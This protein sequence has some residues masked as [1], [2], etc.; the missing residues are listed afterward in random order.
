MDIEQLIRQQAQERG[1]DPDLAVSIARAESSLNPRA[2]NPK[3]S[4]RGLFQVTNDTWKQYG[5]DPKKRMDVNENIRVGLD[6]IA[7]NTAALSSTLGR[8]PRPAE[9]YAA[10]FFG[11]AGA[12]RV[13][14]ADPN[15]PIADVVSPAVMKANKSLL[16][17]K[18]VAQAVNALGRK[19]GDEI[20]AQDV[21]G[22]VP[23]TGARGASPAVARPVDGGYREDPSKPP[24][25]SRAIQATQ[26]LGPGYQAALA[27]SYLADTEE[28]SDDPDEPRIVEREAAEEAAQQTAA[29]ARSSAAQMLANMDFG[30]TPVVGQQ[31]PQQEPVRMFGGGLVRSAFARAVTSQNN[32]GPNFTP[33]EIAQIRRGLAAQGFKEPETPPPSAMDGVLGNMVGRIFAKVRSNTGPNPNRL[34]TAEL[35]ALYGTT[36]LTP[37]MVD[38]PRTEASTSSGSPFA[39]VISRALFG[40][41]SPAGTQIPSYTVTQELLDAKRAQLR[42]SPTA[43]GFGEVMP[44]AWDAYKARFPTLATFT[45]GTAAPVAGLPTEVAPPPLS[46]NTA[47]PGTAAAMLQNILVPTPSIMDAIAPVKMADG[48]LLSRAA[49]AGVGVRPSWAKRLSTGEGWGS[50]AEYDAFL[51]RAR[52]DAANRAY[53]VQHAAAMGFFADGGEVTD[54]YAQMMQ[55]APRERV[56][57][58]QFIRGGLDTAAGMLKGATQAAIGMPGDIESLIRMGVGSKRD[59]VLPTTD[60]VKRTI[61]RF[62]PLN[63]PA[64]PGTGGRTAAEY[65]GE[66]MSPAAATKPLVRG[67][68]AVGEGAVEGFRRAE[69]AVEE[70]VR[71]TMERG[72]KAAEMLQSFSTV[73]SYAVRPPG[74]NVFPEQIDEI[75]ASRE[76][77]RALDEVPANRRDDVAEFIAT[78]GRKYFQ[79]DFA[80]TKDPLYDALKEG[81][82]LPLTETAQFRDYMLSAAREGNPRALE[83]LARNYDM[84]ME[85]LIV[86]RPVPEGVDRMEQR[87]ERLMQEDEALARFVRNLQE[88]P[89][90]AL[91]PERQIPNRYNLFKTQERVEGYPLSRPLTSDELKAVERGDPFYSL[92][93]SYSIPSFMRPD[94]IANELA[95][96]PPERL[97]N[98]SYPEA[99]IAVNQPARFRA[100]WSA[101]VK[102]ARDGK[103]VPK[104]VKMFGLS[105]QPI[106]KGD[107][108]AW[109]QL[110]DPRATEMEGT[111]MGHSVAGYS[112]TGSYGHGGLEAFQSGRAKVYSLRDSKGDPRVTVEVLDTPDGM[113]VTQIKGRYN[114]GP[115]ES[116]VNDVFKLFEQLDASGRLRNIRTESYLAKENAPAD[117]ITGY[118][119]WKTL[120]NEYL[121]GKQ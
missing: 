87:M 6:I 84:A 39:T 79:K 98:M 34:T 92:D 73:P 56:S 94:S 13:L 47:A 118:T 15:A 63:L 85:P 78:K 96:I 88:A 95:Q 108:G 93:R 12:R 104:D 24:V 106:V 31:Q 26:G 33:E 111:I 25:I 77:Q 36:G 9:V 44:E 90:A 86:T 60:D 45:P 17:G 3:S 99:V 50:Q 64:D 74:G 8:A 10:H 61:D 37:K 40:K 116:E 2:K 1:V 121:L 68:Q 5:G 55:G 82:I 28:S 105:P 65:F 120:Y 53:A 59:T 81:R 18:T 115:R 27:L 52:K 58:G 89:G 49:S 48:G 71:R 29:P 4:A 101:A 70:P 21:A 107:K 75:V 117:A 113:E 100:D 97:K 72:G 62:A 57:P 51:K 67:A 7:D 102:R 80:S 41:A 38:A 23:S 35:Q 43:L 83:D 46:L 119:D 54:P 109:H 16:E 76:V 42:G 11:K 20:Q 19:V 32:E 114:A 103:D 30:F 110:R 69:K 66:F 14:A 91:P 112:R 22:A